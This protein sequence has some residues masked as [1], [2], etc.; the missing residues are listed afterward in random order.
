MTDEKSKKNI[1][2][3]GHEKFSLR[4]GWFAKGLEYA[5]G[6]SGYKTDGGADALGLG[7]NMVKA[8]RYWMYAT[9]LIDERGFLTDFGKIVYEHDPYFTDEFT[10]W[11]LHCKMVSHIESATTWYLYF[12]YCGDSELNKEQVFSII[13]RELDAYIGAQSYSEKSLKTDVDVL[14][15]MYSKESTITDPEDKSISPFSELGLI[16]K[17]G[18]RYIRKQP[19]TSSFD[20]DISLYILARIFEEEECDSVSIDR[21]CSGRNGEY[22]LTGLGSVYANEQL[23]ILDSKG[24]IRVNRTAGLDMIYKKDMPE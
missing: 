23:D 19:P 15:G 3:Q 13:K 1:K 16:K 12:N 17:V 8:L 9:E 10:L 11:I 24:Y 14:L 7:S 21:F 4:E 18:N 6:D 20:S 5:S 2:L 22:A